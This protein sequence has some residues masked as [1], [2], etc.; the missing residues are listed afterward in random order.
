[1]ERVALR[2]G[3]R[4]YL[5]ESSG[6]NS[7]LYLIQREIGRGASCVVYE[8]CRADSPRHKVRIKECYP[9]QNPPHR[10][11]QE[12]EWPDEGQKEQAFDR[13]ERA[14]NI[15]LLLQSEEET[16]NVTVHAPLPLCRANGTLYSV[17]EP[18]Y[19]E[20]LDRCRPENLEEML[21]ITCA[22]TRAIQ[23]CHQCGYLHLDI[24]PEN[25]LVLRD[26]PHMVKLLDL[27][28]L[29]CK[30][31]LQTGAVT[32]ISCSRRWA[33]PE[34]RDGRFSRVDERSDLYAIGAVLFWMVMGRE[35]TCDDRS[36]FAR[37]ELDGPLFSRLHPGAKRG[38]DEIFR[39][40]LNCSPAHRCQDAGKLLQLLQQTLRLVQQGKAYLISNVEHVARFVGRRQELDAIRTD[41]EEGKKVV[42]LSGFGG[43]GKSTLAKQ[44]AQI[45]CGPRALYDT[46][47]F[48][49]YQ[50]NTTLKQLLALL[51]MS[52]KCKGHDHRLAAMDQRTLL[53]LDNYDVSSPGEDWE[54]LTSLPC[55]LLVTTRTD[56][57]DWTGE[58]QV[59]QRRV[60]ILEF[61]DLLQLFEQ[62]AGIQ[63]SPEQLPFLQDIFK[64]IGCHTLLA[65]LLA[66]QLRD[67]H[68]SLEQLREN[69][70]DQPEPVCYQKDG[71][72]WEDTIR[73]GL[74]RVFSMAAFTEEERQAMRYIWTLNGIEFSKDDYREWTGTKNLKTLNRLIRLGWVQENREKDLLALHPLISEVVLKNM[75]PNPDNCP[76]I[77]DYIFGFSPYFSDKDQ[78]WNVDPRAALWA[79]SRWVKVCL[80][81]I[82]L[83]DFSGLY[84]ALGAWSLSKDFISLFEKYRQYSDTDLTNSLFAEYE[85]PTPM[86]LFEPFLHLI[87]SKQ[88]DNNN[89]Q[90]LELV[91]LYVYSLLLYEDLYDFEGPTLISLRKTIN[92]AVALFVK[93][94]DAPPL[95]PLLKRSSPIVNRATICDEVI[96]AFHSIGQFAVPDTPA[97]HQLYCIK[98]AKLQK[99]LQVLLAADSRPEQKE[100]LPDLRIYMYHMVDAFQRM[101]IDND[102]HFFQ[103]HLDYVSLSDQELLDYQPPAFPADFAWE[104]KSPE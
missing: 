10:V 31:E 15:Q 3:D 29:V 2:S 34:L 20:T 35:V 21:T 77:S 87:N 50:E 66:K 104:G 97:M 84:S 49:R 19:G 98:Y 8:G 74:D 65:E 44:Y 64:S 71:S 33:A 91:T 11:K 24:K 89:Q 57:S 16:G 69:L 92:D 75:E 62:N 48:F 86:T 17:L 83:K 94:Y 100:L 61:E 82:N 70:F 12:L 63:V 88:S 13:F 7:Y 47:V 54:T 67:S 95:L 90:Y 23:N 85:Q 37:W 42:F 72:T 56:F 36:P 25:V 76:G 45:N 43:I 78:L 55:H 5:T 73:Q 60:D 103:I 14:Y 27:D 40:T 58:D 80:P 96:Y 32:A 41:F 26:I 22:L 81:K 30:N 79:C 59:T 6:P 28:S 4:L 39:R 18:D 46:I 101:G 68:L 102:M 1:M 99:Y 9:A 51:P 38:V 52:Q 53:I 93:L